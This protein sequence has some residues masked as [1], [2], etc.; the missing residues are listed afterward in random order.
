M[1]KFHFFKKEKSESSD[2]I[3]STINRIKNGDKEL[4]EQ[5]INDY[6]PFI[7][8][9]VSL[10]SGKYI[11]IENSEEY[12]IGLSAFNEAIDSFNE[13]MNCSF[14]TFST[15]V[16]KRRLIN[17]VNR[18][19]KNN[20]EYPFTYFREEE[21][22][23]FDEKYLRIDPSDQFRKIEVTEQILSFKKRLSEFGITINDLV[24]SS[25]KHKDSKQLLIEIA[26]LLAF[27]EE[28]FQRL[29]RK[30]NLPMLELLKHV[31]V[32]QR[33]LERN[34]KFIIAVSLILRGEFDIFT[35]LVKAEVKGGKS[36]E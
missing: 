15:Q 22:S 17:H 16:I 8:K 25:P 32:S 9:S 4:R 27:N 6:I 30:K 14:F 24:L 21:S 31:N 7:L 5:F 33:T 29:D 12:S 11:E 34:R 13:N 36:F 18:S 2:S 1:A 20:R 19:Q 35:D 26:R 28:L 3:N 23:E 10:F